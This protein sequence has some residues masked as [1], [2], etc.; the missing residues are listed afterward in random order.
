MTIDASVRSAALLLTLVCLATSAQA[1]LPQTRLHAIAPSGCQIG[2]TVELKV[3]A[4]DDLE[5]LDGLI[6]S[7]PGIKS[8]QK[9]NEQNG[10][11]TPVA[12]TFEVTVGGDVPPGLYDV[13]CT[14]LFGLSNPRRFVVGQRPEI[15]EA[16]NNKVD[17]AE[18]TV[19]ELNT[20]I[21]GKMDGGTDVDWY[22]FSAKKGQ[23]VTIDCWAERIDSAMDATLSVYDASGRRPLRTVRDTK[24]SDP[25]ATFEV[26][27]DG[28]YLA[29]L[30][31][32][33]FRNGATYG[34]RLELHTAPALL[35]A[36]PPA[37]TAGQTARFALYGVNLP[38]STMTDLQV[39]GV[40]LEKLDVD[41]AVPETGDLL[42]VDGRV[43]GVAAGIDAFSYRL[44]SPQGL[45]SPL[46]IGIARTPVVL[47]QEP[48]N[49]AAEAQRVTIPTEVGG[50]FAARGD[51][52]SFR[53]EAKAGQVL[54]IEAYAQ[55]MGS[56]VDAYFNVEQVITDAEGKETLK[57]LATA[58]DD[59]TNLLQNVF[60]TKTDDPQYKLTV[61]AD[62]WYQ[63]TI[64][65]RYWETHGSPDMTY[66]LVIRPETPNFRI[67]AVPA[68]PTAGQ[69]WPVGLR[70]GDS[71]GVHLLAFR[72]DGFEGPIDVRV[73]GLPAG[74]TCS[75]T[76]IGTK[77]ANGFLVFQTSE[78][79]APGWH[80]VK[81]SGTAAI[82]NPELVRAE[83]AAAKAIPEAEKPLVDLRKQIDQ[84]KPKL[85][86]AVQQVDETQKALA[87]K[88]E[89]DGLKKQLEQRQ[90]AQ[91]QAQAAFD[92]ATK[93]LTAQ[94]QVV[95][96]AKATLE[97]RKETRKQGVQTVSHVARTGTVVWASANNQPAVARV[98]EGF[99]FSVLPE[100][101]H[102][103]VQ[104]DG[105]KFEANQ[106]R[107]LLVPVHLAK[108]NEFNEKVQLNA[109]GIPKSANIDAPNIAIE[110]DQ[111]DQVWRIFVKDNAVP[112][113]YSVWLNSQGQVSYSR[114]PAKAERLKQ[115]HEEVKQQVE[116]LKAAVQEA[117][118]AKNEATTKA[119]EAQQQFQ[120]AQQ[121]QQRLTQEKQQADQKLTQAQQAK[122]QTATQ[123]A[124]ADKE[125]QTREAELKSAE[126][127]LAGADAAAKQA[128]AELKQAQEALAGDA[129][130]A[131]KKAAVEQKQQALTAAQQK[132][133][134]AT[135]ARDQKKAARDD[136]QQKRQ[137]AEQAAKQAA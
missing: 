116:A 16:E 128:D 109:A 39:D 22:R 65:D 29:R 105:N 101:A 40:R 112:G 98:A 121:D 56:A 78:N 92:E 134:E 120:Q 108:R 126:E 11:K 84:L 90:Q 45:S 64:R 123:L 5:E 43:R 87:A 41:I 79:V 127:Q 37:G 129:E 24:G 137:A 85:D 23:R 32:H 77:E 86:Q 35:F 131:E 49:T 67:V 55:R 97:Q 34:Y 38:G 83:E 76:T 3:T 20:V 115:A 27:A 100:L 25:V 107:Q 44:N 36:L 66:R 1:Q 13:R 42:D 82:D 69:V 72:Q 103:Q 17:P 15:V 106:S 71:F 122:D 19:V 47:E 132:A 81:I 136:S 30:H 117:M 93:K 63:V 114:N 73:E 88:P 10:V 2:Q 18:A 8:V 62:G 51:S 57:R 96:Q 52:D 89:D 28:E 74:V 135:K 110:K 46:R 54:F 7:H 12:N 95:A 33:T 53:F 58:D 48:N 111:A 21:N 125:L 119:N 50:Q 75:G 70:K 61:P 60:E 104:L 59:A 26:P 80:R 102:F 6:F 133:A 9:F 68:A 124:A 4:G 130:N 113:T 99:A 118:K 14:G 94:E 31:D 91:Q